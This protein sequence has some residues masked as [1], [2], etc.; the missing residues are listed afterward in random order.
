MKIKKKQTGKGGAKSRNSFI[1]TDECKSNDI[2]KNF[3]RSQSQANFYTKQNQ[4]LTIKSRLVD[5]K[6]SIYNTQTVAFGS[7]P[8]RELTPNYTQH[9]NVPSDN[10][11]SLQ[12]LLGSLDPRSQRNMKKTPLNIATKLDQDMIKNLK[13]LFMQFSSFVEGGTMG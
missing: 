8:S 7:R 6:S 11:I 4:G 2:D 5:Q 3:A 9:Q 13:V 12:S 1:T 10:K